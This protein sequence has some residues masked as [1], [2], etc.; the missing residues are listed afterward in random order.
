[1]NNSILFANHFIYI[2]SGSTFKEV[3]LWSYCATM[4]LQ[5]PRSWICPG[6]CDVT[7]TSQFITDRCEIR[8]DIRKQALTLTL[9][10]VSFLTIRCYEILNTGHLKDLQLLRVGQFVYLKQDGYDPSWLNISYH[11][12]SV[13]SLIP[14]AV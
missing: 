8:L 9:F 12:G 14:S 4:S 1:M 6:F 11:I 13:K 10:A 2:K 5:K 3:V 7:L